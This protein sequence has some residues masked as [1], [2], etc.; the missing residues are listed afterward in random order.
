MRE[1]TSIGGLLVVEV[2]ALLALIGWWGGLSPAT[3]LLHLGAVMRGEHVPTVPPDGVVAQSAWLSG[4]RLQRLT[5]MV[6]LLVVA[7]LVGLGEGIARR[8]TDAL[9]GFRLTWW[10]LGMVGLALMPGA[11][12]GY[13]LAPW[14]LPALRV[15]RGL[16]L[17]IALVMYG[18]ASGR[19]YVP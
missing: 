1:P 13:L 4:Q 6:G 17:V 19:P 5:G 9:G 8:R 15:A 12:A 7:G 16:A 18:L 3:R 2:L 14:P 10:V 11:I